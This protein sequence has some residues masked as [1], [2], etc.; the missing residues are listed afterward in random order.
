MG[1]K[2]VEGALE[3]APN[4]S[5][6]ADGL[7]FVGCLEVVPGEEFAEDATYEQITEEAI[8]RGNVGPSSCGQWYVHVYLGPDGLAKA[9][10]TESFVDREYNESWEEKVG[11]LL[12]AD[13]V[14]QTWACEALREA[15][16]AVERILAGRAEEEA[17]ALATIAAKH[18]KLATELLVLRGLVAKTKP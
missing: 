9:E 17:A 12:N 13:T 5:L 10:L 1:L 14:L 11:V 7:V 6:E 16:V 15:I 18:E 4:T 3:L 2:I 8:R